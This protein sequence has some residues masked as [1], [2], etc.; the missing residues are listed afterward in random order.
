VAAGASV[1][2]VALLMGLVGLD[3]DFAFDGGVRVYFVDIRV[4]WVRVYII[5]EV[6]GN[7]VIKS[8]IQL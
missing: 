6:I 4:Y 2:G 3:L 8:R 5:K 7:R 1:A